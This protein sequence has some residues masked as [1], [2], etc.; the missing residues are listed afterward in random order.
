MKPLQFRKPT[1]L[2]DPPLR[3]EKDNLKAVLSTLLPPEVLGPR[4]ALAE[5]RALRTEKEEELERG[6]L[7]HRDA[8]K[9]NNAQLPRRLRD[10]E[11]EIAKLDAE[12][13][14]LRIAADEAR[15]RWTPT[16][17]RAVRPHLKKAEPAILDA[18]ALLESAAELHE[19]SDDFMRTNGLN[20]YIAPRSRRLYD[21]AAGARRFVGKK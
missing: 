15:L 11:T 3:A 19:I 16:A 8:T 13:A 18:I 17:I 4:Q 9:N 1:F 21:L 20:A 7:E 14:A 2:S 5:R 6:C 10:L 12:I